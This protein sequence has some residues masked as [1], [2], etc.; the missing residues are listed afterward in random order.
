MSSAVMPSICIL[1]NISGSSSSSNSRR[2][3]LEIVPHA[4]SLTK[5]PM[6]RRLKIISCCCSQSKERTT[7]LALTSTVAAYSRT[8]G[9]RPPSE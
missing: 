1:R 6:P 4:P 3:S 2:R 8:D 5:Y 7:V 9:M